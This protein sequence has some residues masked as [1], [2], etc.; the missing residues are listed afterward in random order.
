MRVVDLFAGAGGLSNLT[1]IKTN[2]T[3]AIS[4]LVEK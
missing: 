3:C 2:A 1:F 4:A